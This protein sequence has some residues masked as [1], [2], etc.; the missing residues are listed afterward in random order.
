MILRSP[1]EFLQKPG[2]AKALQAAAKL[3]EHQQLWEVAQ[4]A[5]S[6]IDQAFAAKFTA[7]AVT[8]CFQGSPHI[9]KQNTAAFYGLALGDFPEGQGGIR[10]ECSSRI[11]A[12][13]NTRNRLGKVDGRN[14]HWVAPYDEGCVRYSL[15]YYQTDGELAPVGPAIFATPGSSSEMC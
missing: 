3:T 6:S 14:P 15:I 1:A 5:L 9:D 2:S 7:L 4:K 13:V 8:H 12:E 10:V 11:V